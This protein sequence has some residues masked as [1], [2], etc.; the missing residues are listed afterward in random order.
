[1]A[2][3]RPVTQLHFLR[4]VEVSRRAPGKCAHRASER[5]PLG[6]EGE[7]LARSLV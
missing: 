2:D 5:G 6:E 4:A 1:M 7:V 3:G